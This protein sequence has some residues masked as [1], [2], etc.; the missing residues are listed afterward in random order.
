MVICSLFLFSTLLNTKQLRDLRKDIQIIF[1]DPFGSL[2]Q[3]ITVGTMLNKI[4]KLHNFVPRKE[5]LIDM[6]KLLSGLPF[7]RLKEVLLSDNIFSKTKSDI[8]V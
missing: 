8:Y 2:N 3:P 6:Q 1:Q 7:C 4:V 5:I